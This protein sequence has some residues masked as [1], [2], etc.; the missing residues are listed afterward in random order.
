MELLEKRLGQTEQKDGLRGLFNRIFIKQNSSEKEYIS[1]LIISLKN[2]IRQD[3]YNKIESLIFSIQSYLTAN[4]LSL[5]TDQLQ[6]LL[7]DLVKTIEIRKR[8]SEFDDISAPEARDGV[9]YI[10]IEQSL[11]HRLGLSNGECYGYVM[12]LA[13]LLHGSHDADLKALGDFH[14]NP[15]IYN[16]QK[17]RTHRKEDNLQIKKERI[18]LERFEVN[19]KKQALEILLIAKQ[20]S[21]MPFFLRRNSSKA[22]GHACYIQFVDNNKIIYMD[23]NFGVYKF[24]NQDLFIKYYLKHSNRYH[25]SGLKFQRYELSKLHVDP[26]NTVFE[27]RNYGGKIRSFLTGGKYNNSISNSLLDLATILLSIAVVAG[28]STAVG[29]GVGALIGSFLIPIPIVGTIIGIVIGVSLCV[30]AQKSSYAGVLA[31][32]NY[33]RGLWH[34]FKEKVFSKKLD[35]I[36][37]AYENQANNM[38]VEVEESMSSFRI[39]AAIGSGSHKTHQSV[40]YTPSEVQTDLKIPPLPIVAPDRRSISLEENESTSFEK[41]HSSGCY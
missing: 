24:S 33:L 11:D 17:N 41:K 14:F 23:P 26:D 3:D 19:Y 4:K 37:P 32:P 6:Y 31:V 5:F 40:V 34:D 39:M 1:L 22:G 30:L 38:P 20:Q 35:T 21:G 2:R 16:F 27:S 36:E 28:I 13:R 7:A 12:E 15:S 8:K 18:T 10:R 9:G 29:V 25:D